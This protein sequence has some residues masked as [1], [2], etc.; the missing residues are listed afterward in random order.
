MV[1]RRCILRA[2][3]WVMRSFKDSMNQDEPGW[4]QTTV[5]CPTCREDHVILSDERQGAMLPGGGAP[6]TRRRSHIAPGKPDTWCIWHE[7]NSPH[8][9]APCAYCRAPLHCHK[10][11]LGRVKSGASGFVVERCPACH[12]YNAVQ[13]TYGKTPGITTSPMEEGEPVLQLSLGRRWTE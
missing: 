6:A 3:R 11:A 12:L 9:A 10:D 5:Y 13:P 4:E 2:P 8:L 7:T 1:Y